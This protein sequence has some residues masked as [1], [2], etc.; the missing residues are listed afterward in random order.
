MK[1][2]QKLVINNLADPSP[3]Q[4]LLSHISVDCVVFGFEDNELKVLL[5]Q[6]DGGPTH[7]SWALPGNFIHE[8]VEL[9]EVPYL[10]LE[11]RTGIKEIFVKQLGSFGALDRVHYRRVITI[12]FYALVNAEKY[13][14]KSGDGA[15]NVQ[16]FSL[17]EVPELVFDH[18]EILEHALDRLR[19]DLHFFP[20]GEELLPSKFTLTQLQQLYEAILDKE[21]DTRNFRRKIKSSKILK[22]TGEYDTNVPYRNPKLY[23]FNKKV[24]NEKLNEGFYFQL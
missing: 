24:Y 9:E 23:Q 16:W 17:Q 18:N 20:I 13:E 21:L 6:H 8:D 19:R 3:A 2:N 10:I 14:L 22:D 1:N 4:G 5:L 11:Q 12:S 15:K 7:N